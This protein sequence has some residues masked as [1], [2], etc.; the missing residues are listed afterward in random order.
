MDTRAELFEYL[1]QRH[2]MGA[3]AL[4][5]P[6]PGQVAL[7]RAV[8]MALRAPDHGQLRPFRFVVVP[9]AQRER[10]AR[11]FALGAQQRGRNEV[12]IEQ[13]RAR[14]RNGPAL[15]ALVG[16]VRS[17]VADVPESEQWV[18]IG[19]GLMNFLNALHLMGYGAKALSGASVQDAC[20]RDAFCAPGETLVAWVL[21]GTPLSAARPRG[22]DDAAA[23]LSQ[24]SG[25]H[26]PGASSHGTQA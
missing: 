5:S 25:E 14:A 4:G 20:I 21:A 7:T 22:A 15:V 16:R 1:A 12:E 17:G 8:R 24:W 9:D 23:A 18:C 3:K 6:A 11:L 2:S 19:A 13:A 10:L 26:T